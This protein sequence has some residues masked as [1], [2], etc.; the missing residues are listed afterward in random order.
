MTSLTLPH[1]PAVEFSGVRFRVWPVLLA[2]VLMQAVLWPARELA[3]WIAHRGAEFFDANVWAF[4]GLAMVLQTLAGLAC[5]AVMRHLL[6]QAPTYLRWPTRGQGLIGLAFAIGIGMAATM[7]VA[8]WWPQLLAHRAPDGVGRPQVC[9]PLSRRTWVHPRDCTA[10][11]RGTSVA[12]TMRMQHRLRVACTL[13][14]LPSCA[15]HESAGADAADLPCA[16]QAVARPPHPHAIA[17]R[18]PLGRTLAPATATA[19]EV[20]PQPPRPEERGMWKIAHFR[21]SRR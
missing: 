17:Q 9:R 5:I 15:H 6:P 16:T 20:P 12:R 14:L 13:L 10:E 4:V 3:R 1:R 18:T 19:G 8:D 11:N 2:A 7:L 21:D